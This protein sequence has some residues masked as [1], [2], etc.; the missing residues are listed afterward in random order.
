MLQKKRK[1]EKKGKTTA[2]AQNLAWLLNAGS[3]NATW[4]KKKKFMHH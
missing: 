2:A 1:E 4:A 3:W